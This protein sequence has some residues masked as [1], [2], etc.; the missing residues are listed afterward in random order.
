M[1]GAKPGELGK[2]GDAWNVDVVSLFNADSGL[3]ELGGRSHSE[4]P[5]SFD[6]VVIWNC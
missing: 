1:C 2:F 3:K 6:E 5:R 4:R